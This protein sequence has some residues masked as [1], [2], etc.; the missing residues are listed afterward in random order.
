MIITVIKKILKT[1][2]KAKTTTT[3]AHKWPGHYHHTNPKLH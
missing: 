1:N 3:T 2:I